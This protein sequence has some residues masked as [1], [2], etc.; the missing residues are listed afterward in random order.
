AGLVVEDHDGRVPRYAPGPE[1]RSKH[2]QEG[3]QRCIGGV[4]QADAIDVEMPASLDMAKRKILRRTQVNQRKRPHS[5]A[6]FARVDQV[7]AV[8]KIA[9]RHGEDSDVKKG[10]AAVQPTGTVALIEA[11]SAKRSYQAASAARSVR[12]P[13]SGCRKSR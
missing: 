2:R 9:D 1:E 5:L 13:M 3:V 12:Q 8:R 11:R 6:Q 4:T 10:Q 7:S